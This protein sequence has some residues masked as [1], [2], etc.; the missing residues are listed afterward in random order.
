MPQFVDLRLIEEAQGRKGGKKYT[1]SEQLKP[2]R[3]EMLNVTM[4]EELHYKVEGDLDRNFAETQERDV[5]SNLPTLAELQQEL[6]SSNMP[7][8]QHGSCAGA[9]SAEFGKY[10]R[11]R[12]AERK[13]LESMYTH[14]VEVKKALDF[15]ARKEERKAE[16][17]SKTAKRA[18]KRKKKDEAAKKRKEAFKKQ[19]AENG[20]GPKQ[21]GD[22]QESEDSEPEVPQTEPAAQAVND[23]PQAEPAAQG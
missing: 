1:P 21:E 2:R 13:R 22:P 9:S 16:A 11:K 10:L 4:E 3:P 14:G 17:E 23:V 5:T 18:A 20:Q 6:K 12:D 7:S 8:F 15:E 19:K